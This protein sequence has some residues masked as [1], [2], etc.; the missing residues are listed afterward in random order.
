MKPERPA[1]LP[2]V[3]PDAADRADADESHRRWMSAALDGDAAAVEAAC[4]A[5]RH[6]A[7]AREAWHGYH[8]IGDA[9]RSSE[10][11]QA[12]ARDEAFLQA[13]R[14]RLAS[15]PVVLAPQGRRPRSAWWGPAAATV[16]GVA[17]VAAVTGVLVVARALAPGAVELAGAAPA[18]AVRV[19]SGVIRDVQLDEYLRVHQL[20]RGG[21]GSALPGST[22][23]RVDF[24][25]ATAPAR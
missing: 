25:A 3:H 6:S 12:P 4:R 1:T 11:A 7:A 23:R 22:L 5:W 16:A 18:S 8:L 2:G 21:M 19:D 24:E 14:T 9:L 10:L 17:A 13:L 20:A 15:E